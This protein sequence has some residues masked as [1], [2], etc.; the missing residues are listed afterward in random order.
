MAWEHIPPSLTGWVVLSIRFRTGPK[1][2]VCWQCPETVAQA[3]LRPDF[4]RVN[5]NLSSAFLRNL[6]MWVSEQQDNHHFLSS[7]ST[8]NCRGQ[9]AKHPIIYPII[10]NI[11][12]PCFSS[13]TPP[14]WLPYKICSFPH[15]PAAPSLRAA[16]QFV[17]NRLFFYP[18]SGQVQWFYSARLHWANQFTVKI[19]K[20]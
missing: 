12:D 3:Q 17:P 4:Y 11:F 18:E 6:I 13:K 16:P 2:T 14:F 9:S 19:S 15:R 7:F 8:G 20:Y 1:M 5:R 10:A